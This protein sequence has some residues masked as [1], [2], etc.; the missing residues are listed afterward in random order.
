MNS[1]KRKDRKINTQSRIIERQMDE[2]E[3]L[4]KKVSTLEISC[5]EKDEIINSIDS[6][7]IEMQEVIDDIK[8][9]GEVY[10]RLIEELNDMK[11]VMNE[12]VFKNRWKLVRLLIK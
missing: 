7:R 11:K 4:K 8:S 5:E 3:S 6:L 10:D 1:N 9:K 2:I 12:E